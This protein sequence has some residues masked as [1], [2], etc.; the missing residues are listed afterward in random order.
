MADGG[1]LLL[2]R[3][4]RA[5]AGDVPRKEARAVGACCWPGTMT[6]GY[7]IQL[8]GPAKGGWK[9]PP[10]SAQQLC[11]SARAPTC[12]PLVRPKVRDLIFR[13]TIKILP[14]CTYLIARRL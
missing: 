8:L 5:G 6:D 10:W 7:C 4:G 12:S 14:N 11:H 3:S 1:P 9:G 13:L 2:A